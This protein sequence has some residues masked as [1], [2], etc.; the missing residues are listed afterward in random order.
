[1]AMSYGEFVARYTQV[2][3]KGAEAWRESDPQLQAVGVRNAENALAQA[4]TH[5]P[6][7]VD[8]LALLGP[9]LG[10]TVLAQAKGE[11]E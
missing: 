10:G 2:V 9:E 8:R 7:Y 4:D 1:M 11:M 3:S 5:F 6:H